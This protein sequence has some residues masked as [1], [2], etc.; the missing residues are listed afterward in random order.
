MPFLRLPL[1]RVRLPCDTSPEMPVLRPQGGDPQ[2]TLLISTD[3]ALRYLASMGFE[4]PELSMLLGQSD[5]RPPKRSRAVRKAHIPSDLRW[6]VWER[7]DFTCQHCGSRRHLSIDH[8]VP[9]SKGGATT[10]ANLQTLCMPCNR[11]K[12]AS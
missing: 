1:A 8:I 3:E 7:D 11:K 6:E 12:A 2:V 10:R 4:R 5:L 9:E